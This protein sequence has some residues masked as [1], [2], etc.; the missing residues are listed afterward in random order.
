MPP[1]L[2]SITGI[3]IPPIYRHL[4]FAILQF[5]ISSLMNW[6][7]IQVWTGFSACKTQVWN[8]K[9]AKSKIPVRVVKNVITQS[10]QRWNFQGFYPFDS[11]SSEST[12][13]ETGNV[14][15]CEVLGVN[16]WTK[17]I[18]IFCPSPETWQKIMME[19][20]KISSWFWTRFFPSLSNSI[21]QTGELEKSSS[22]K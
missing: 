2:N 19:L 7:F 12:R 3:A 15:L 1:P 6:I 20:E 9:L 17:T 13:T 4:I 10:E 14:F 18:K 8:V 21:F 16:I 22:D 5:E 11:G